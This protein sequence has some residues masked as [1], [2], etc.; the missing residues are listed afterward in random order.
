MT[1][2]S[3]QENGWLRPHRTSEQEVLS[4]LEL[5]ERDLVDAS[6]SEISTDWRF[7]IAY[8]AGL[9][10]ATIVLYAAGYRAGRGGYNRIYY[11]SL[12]WVAE[13]HAGRT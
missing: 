10:L 2:E 13:A 7:N 4:I 11:V 6:R 8:N 5:V 12:Q 9:Q 1:L 3:W